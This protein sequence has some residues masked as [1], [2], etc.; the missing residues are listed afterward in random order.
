MQPNEITLAVDE[1]NSGSTTDHD[2]TRID[3]FSNRSLYCRDGVH[4]AA[5]RDQLNFYR[6]P[7]KQNGNYRGSEKTSTKFTVDT[8]VPGVDGS[9]IVAPMIVETKYSFPVG[10]PAATK[11][12][13]RQKAI[14]LQDLDSVMDDLHGMLE[15]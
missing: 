2:F 7:G 11:K 14:A 13:M 6:T 1:A 15:I 4:T 9:D 3:S 10:T 5:A 8:T 12:L